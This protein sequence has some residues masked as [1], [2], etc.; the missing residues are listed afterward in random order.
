MEYDV[1][2]KFIIIPDEPHRPTNQRTS[3][4]PAQFHPTVGTAR[5]IQRLYMRTE[6]CEGKGERFGGSSPW[7][8]LCPGA[9]ALLLRPSSWSWSWSQELRPRPAE[10]LVLARKPPASYVASSIRGPTRHRCPGYLMIFLRP[11]V[12]RQLHR[13]VVFC[14]LPMRA[15][16]GDAILRGRYPIGPLFRVSLRWSLLLLLLLFWVRCCHFRLIVVNPPPFVWRW[17]IFRPLQRMSAI[18]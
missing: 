9:G 3:H 18:R 6:G 7:S 13:A 1:P 4:L 16:C 8:D 11:R 10:R 12:V 15:L 17:C 2:I 14:R 5:I